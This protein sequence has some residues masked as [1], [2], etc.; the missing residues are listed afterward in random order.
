MSD[1]PATAFPTAT[2]AQLAVA[3]LCE[4]SSDARG[5]ALLDLAGE[6]LA[7]SG[8]LDRW[9]EAARGFLAAA[10]AAAGEPATHAHVATED[11]EAFAVRQGGLAMVAVAERFTLASLL[12]CDMRAVLRDLA[13]AGA[14]LA[15]A[16]GRS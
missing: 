13:R 15:S 10:D 1:G 2:D 12:L 8:E 5:C 4:M 7:A 3:R 14:P 9:G 6:P 11:G 16:G